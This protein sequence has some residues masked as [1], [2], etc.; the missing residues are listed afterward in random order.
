MNPTG[1]YSAMRTCCMNKRASVSGWI[2]GVCLAVL[3]G[4]GGAVPQE[5]QGT[6][7][8][9]DQVQ[10][11]VQMTE[12]QPLDL[13]AHKLLP[14]LVT[15]HDPSIFQDRDGRYYIV[16]T[17]ITSAR[18]SDLFDWEQ[19]D[20]T[21][22]SA[23]DSES[24]K[25]IRAYNDDFKAGSPVGYL[26]APDMIYNEAMGK[27]CVYLSANGDHW[28]SN[29][30]LLT[31]D[32]PEGPFTYAG[33]VVYGG[34]TQENWQETDVAQVLGLD[35]AADELPQ[36]YILNGV[37]N[38]HW[39]DKFP[40]CIDP[41]V[42]YDE[43]GRLWMSYGSWSGGIFLLQLDEETGLRDYAVSYP[44]EKHSDSYFG[45][46]IAG[47]AYVSGEASYIQHIG[48]YYWLFISYGNLE[49]NGGYNIRV[50]RSEEPEGP[51]V[52]ERGNSPF[53]DSYVQN[54]NF[55]TGERLFGAYRW[56]TAEVGMVAQGHNSALVDRDGRAY[57]VYHTRTDNGT[58]YHY[59]RV[60]QLFLN[61][62]GWL[63]AAPYRTHGEHLPE[64]G[65]AQEQL[66]GE[67]EV[68]LHRLDINYAQKQCSIPETIALHADGT[69][70]GDY[71]GHWE[72]MENTPYIT[73]KLESE[74]DKESDTYDGVALTMTIDDTDL[75]TV[76]FTALGEHN[77]LT[78]WGSKIISDEP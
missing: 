76:V 70:T 46:L 16:G 68:I 14:Q 72:T 25:Q 57:I 55:P 39:G 35:V 31:G 7:A 45:Q 4:C 22:R 78:L 18:S 34:F 62:N 61:Q 27:Y 63:V 2:F 75:E 60:H 36:R 66:V 77:Q 74:H 53:Y 15:V 38:S 47:G 8:S 49:A 73:L 44:T 69:I 52:D 28:Q 19:T 58:E 24:M 32:T 37:A 40:N 29:I 21:F 50:F 3:S 11:E 23:I 64:T 9:L 59:V 41:C 30:V 43:E 54:Y 67:Y 13:A 1:R 51:Y 6:A 5:G 65:L 26:W 56:S 17:H 42:F 20:T 10:E 33:S 71:G 48:D 12:R